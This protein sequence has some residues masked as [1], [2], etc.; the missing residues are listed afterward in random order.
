MFLL[1]FL[2]LPLPVAGPRRGD[3]SKKY[4]F[5][6]RQ[7]QFGGAFCFCCRCGDVVVFCCRPRGALFVAVV[8]EAGVHPLTGF[9]GLRRDST[10]KKNNDG[11][12][13]CS[14]LSNHVSTVTT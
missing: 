2:L 11:K 6:Q 14:T 7:Q 3:D 4:T 13:Q 8:P 9:L 1:S 12:K 10:K 5:P